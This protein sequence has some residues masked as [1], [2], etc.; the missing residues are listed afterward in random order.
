MT[1]SQSKKKQV[2]ETL[3][4]VCKERGN[5]AFSNKEVKQACARIGFGKK[6]NEI[7]K[8]QDLKGEKE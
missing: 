7:G 2:L 8:D 5:F 1:Q 4:A 3:Y 6:T